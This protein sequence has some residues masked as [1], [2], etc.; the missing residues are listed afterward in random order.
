MFNIK[1]KSYEDI[2]KNIREPLY[3]YTVYIGEL[4][5]DVCEAIDVEMGK[6]QGN[7][8]SILV[9]MTFIITRVEID[10]PEYFNYINENIETVIAYINPSTKCFV[11]VV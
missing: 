10:N 8:N 6:Q 4:K 9:N 1:L 5:K 11:K 3:T 2:V 7:V